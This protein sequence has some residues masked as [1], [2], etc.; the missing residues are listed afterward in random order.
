VIKINLLPVRA[1]RKK[2][3]IRYQVSMYL[4][5]VVFSVC[6]MGYLTI[7]MGSKTSDLNQKIES[8]ILLTYGDSNAPIS[9]ASSM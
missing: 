6:V 4:L 3:N 8:V 9:G 1:A 7:S 2:E 5:C